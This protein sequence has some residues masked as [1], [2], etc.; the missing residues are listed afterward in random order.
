MADGLP[1]IA[2][3]DPAAPFAWRGA[4]PVGAGE[5]LADAR[6]LAQRLPA[7]GAMLD[8]CRDRYAFS[9]AFAAA[10]LR[11]HLVVLPNSLVRANLAHLAREHPGLYLASEVAPP[12][13]LPSDVPVIDASPASAGDVVPASADAAVAGFT[14]DMPRIDPGRVVACLF[15]SGSTG[16]PAAHPRRWGEI[17]AS[18][19]AQAAR[20]GIGPSPGWAI[21]G[22]VPAQHSYGFEST[23]MLAWHAPAALSAAHPFY[24]AD[25]CA[26]LAELPRPRLLVTTPVH[27]RALAGSAV[28]NPAADLVLSATAPLA[29]SA[30]ALAERRFGC[31]MLEIYGSTES[32]QLASRRTTAGDAWEALDGVAI[33]ADDD[34]AWASGGHVPGRVRLGDRITCHDARHF[35]LHGRVGDQINVAGKRGSLRHVE[36]CLLAVDGVLEAAILADD[37]PHDGAVRRLIGF[38]VAP[39]LGSAQVLAQLRDALDPAFVPRPLWQVDALPRDG[40]GKVPRAAL[41]ALA[42]RLARGPASPALADAGREGTRVHFAADA[43]YFRGHFPGRPLVPGA[44]LLERVLATMPGARP[45]HAVVR[46]ERVKFLSPVGPDDIVVVDWVAASPGL[47]FV[48]RDGAR[49]VASGSVR[50]ARE[51]DEGTCAGAPA[52]LAPSAP[53]AGPR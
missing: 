9:V 21:V 32:G 3:A 44:K 6:A 13:G 41:R 25:V 46:L 7:R 17:V 34:A 36:Q 30:A 23:I 51:R 18:A 47:R 39:G 43:P 20:L 19:R 12:A 26:A 38:V 1:L 24:P 27:L 14:R 37:D 49:L 11:G 33:T 15:T 53:P 40:N 48:C 45:A 50:L 29:A 16:T 10:L 4:R 35:V 31:A 2:H 42:E 52:G 8:A 28:A 5:F 22:T